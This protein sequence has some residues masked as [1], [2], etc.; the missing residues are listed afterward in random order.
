[1]KIKLI[2]SFLSLFLITRPV[3]AGNPPTLLSPSD[4]STVPSSKLQWQAPVYSLA[5]PNPYRIQVDDDSTFS[6]INK[7]YYTDNIYYTPTLSLGNWYWRVKA[8]DTSGTWSD[9]SNIWSFIL[10]DATP[11]PSPSSTPSPTPTPTPAPTQTSSP[12]PI[13]KKSTSPTDSPSTAPSPSPS[14]D[15]PNTPDLSKTPIATNKLIYHI[16]SVAAATTSAAPMGKVE[17]KNE[18]QT[19]PFVWV[20]L[21]FI[22][23]GV[24]AIG[25][26]YLIKNA[27]IHIPFGR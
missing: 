27:K 1:M 8:K 20:G 23:A 17:V 19:N 3:L 21:V 7:D 16:A 9:W 15:P 26:I 4:N 18:K 12:A 13:P 22:F 14:T 10:S 25:Y 24:A 6:S 11:T 5:S 2:V